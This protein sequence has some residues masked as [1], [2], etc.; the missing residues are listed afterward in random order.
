MA[1]PKDVF[2]GMGADDAEGS[3]DAMAE[4]GPSEAFTSMA[5]GLFPDFDEAK[6]AQLWELIKECTEGGY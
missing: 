5:K 6:T 1:E 4:S 2:G 3:D